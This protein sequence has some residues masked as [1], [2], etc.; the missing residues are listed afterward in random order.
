MDAYIYELDGWMMAWYKE[1]VG[2]EYI[3][4][5]FLP[6]CERMDQLSYYFRAGFSPAEAVQACFGAK[7]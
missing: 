2:M 4:S 1:A 6:D 7:H 3:N 5:P